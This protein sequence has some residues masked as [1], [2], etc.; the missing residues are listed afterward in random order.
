MNVIAL[1]V[2]AIGILTLVHLALVLKCT[3]WHEE[4]TRVI[5]S[6]DHDEAWRRRDNPPWYARYVHWLIG[7]EI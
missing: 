5:E 3:A 7:D 6:G 4:I 2:A 1:I